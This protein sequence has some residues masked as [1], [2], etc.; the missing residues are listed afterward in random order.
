MVGRTQGGDDHAGDRAAIVVRGEKGR[1]AFRTHIADGRWLT[2]EGRIVPTMAIGKQKEHTNSKNLFNILLSSIGGIVLG[3]VASILGKQFLSSK[4]EESFVV[5]EKATLAE[6][7][8]L[9]K[10]VSSGEYPERT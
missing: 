5:A 6:D 10:M 9:R 7:Q 4:E 3:V 1:D 2:E 8:D